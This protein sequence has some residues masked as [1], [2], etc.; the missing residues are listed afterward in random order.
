MLDPV[1]DVFVLAE[2]NTTF[3]QKPK[4]LEFQQNRKRFEPFLHKV[5]HVVV[6]DSPSTGDPRQ[7]EAF[8]RNAVMQGLFDP[9]PV[10]EKDLI[11][12]SD[13]DEVP[14][15]RHVCLSCATE[16]TTLTW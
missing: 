9:S 8:Q 13:V 2:S 4:A 3:S 6:D 10:G 5:R 1:V 15:P 11:I 7:N 16:C 14:D 12:I